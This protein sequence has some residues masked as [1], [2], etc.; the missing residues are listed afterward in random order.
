MARRRFSQ[1]SNE[2]IFAFLLFTAKKHKFVCLFYGRIYGTQICLWFY[3]TFTNCG[4]PYK[5]G[6]VKFDTNV[7]MCTCTF[8]CQNKIFKNIPWYCF[9]TVWLVDKI[10]QFIIEPILGLST[11]QFFTFTMSQCSASWFTE[12]ILNWKIAKC[13]IEPILGLSTL[14]F[15]SFT[16]SQCLMIHRKFFYKSIELKKK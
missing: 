6:S 15:F 7:L 1:K 13:I 12:T 10:K 16:L 14:Q 11:L 9:G 5:P 3:L 8:N 2:W 4:N